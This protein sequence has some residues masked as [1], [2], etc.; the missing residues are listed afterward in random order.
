MMGRFFGSSPGDK[1][2]LTP[3]E[4]KFNA[5]TKAAHDWACAEAGKEPGDESVEQPP[6]A[7]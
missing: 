3:D 2:G 5:D 7:W 6:G 4:E 1:A